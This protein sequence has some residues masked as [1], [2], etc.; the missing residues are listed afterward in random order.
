MLFSKRTVLATIIFGFF[1]VLALIILADYAEALFLI[2]MG[3]IV[4]PVIL[5]WIYRKIRG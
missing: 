3:W 1:A 5:L 2:L 4:L